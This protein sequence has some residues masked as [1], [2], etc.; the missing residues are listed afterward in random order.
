[1]ILHLNQS[2][3]RDQ[4]IEFLL[5][6]KIIKAVEF[7]FPSQSITRYI[8]GHVSIY[9]IIQSLKINSYFTHFSAMKF[10]KLTE[11]TPDT[12]YLN[13]EQPPKRY[14]NRSLDQSR[15]DAA[16]KRPLIVS[17]NVA[18]Y[19]K[20]RICILNGIYTGRLGVI[21]TI[22][23]RARVIATDIERTLIDI[24]V[25]PGYSG[26]VSEVLNAYKLAK[27]KL[28]V[29]KLVNMLD[30]L[31]FVY[32]YHQAIDFYLDKSGCY[33]HSSINLLRGKGLKY[34][35]YLAHNIKEMNYS[36]EW[37]LFFPNNL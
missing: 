31:K 29:K 11:Q 12:I 6:K 17:Q 23:N 9:E 4:F 33:D 7:G 10:H 18:E 3:T 5:K 21:E 26:G 2:I 22:H 19:K 36:K 30:T 24:V 8:R 37:R 15:I 16:F 27:D 14:K 32:P 35:F 20:Y 34:D 1:M 28:S 13:F 25:R